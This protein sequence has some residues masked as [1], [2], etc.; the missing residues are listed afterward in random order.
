MLCCVVLCCV[1]ALRC[2]KPLLQLAVLF[3]FRVMLTKVVLVPFA[4]MFVNSP[5]KIEQFTEAHDY[6]T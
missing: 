1:V 5:E 6:S 2:R 3:V 4:K